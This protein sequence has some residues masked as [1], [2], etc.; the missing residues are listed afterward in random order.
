VL[1]GVAAA[2]KVSGLLLMGGLALTYASRPARPHARTLAPFAGLA[3][4]AVI[5]LPILE[6]EAHRGWPMLHHRLVDTQ[7][8]SGVSLRNAAAVLGGQLA[9]LSP[10]TAVLAALAARELW[11]GRDDPK[12]RLLLVCCLLPFAV[13][14]PLCLWSRVAEPHWLAPALLSL[15]PA[16]AR[17]TAPP[18]RRL[19]VLSCVIAGAMVTA[20]HAWVLVPSLLRLAPASYDA[21]L[22]LANELY[23][24]PE[25]MRAV[26]DELGTVA[27]FTEKEGRDIAVVG[28]HWVICA[29]LDAALEGRFPVGCDGPLRD[30]FDDWLPRALW[31]RFDV[32]VWVT[33]TRFARV[34]ELPAHTTWRSREVAIE[35]GGRTVRL[36]T[37]AVL[38]RTASALRVEP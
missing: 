19:V 12:G 1:A 23:G 27:P 36:F 16:A 14:L 2:S 31:R 21:R 13:L 26:H 25:V 17:A 10:L 3:A 9:Y 7:A 15:V 20:A 24:W 30:D 37:I 33:D 4:G 6:F 29:Q 18:P 8:A 11:R 34:P 35:R 28:P 38:G 32:I 22:D 5:L